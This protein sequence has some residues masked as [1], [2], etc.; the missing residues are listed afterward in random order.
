[1]LARDRSLYELRVKAIEKISNQEF[2][3]N[4]Y[5]DTPEGHVRLAIINKIEDKE[6]LRFVYANDMD[7]GVSNQALALLGEENIFKL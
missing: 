3:K 7:I 6:F 5:F 1:M 4:L 2:L